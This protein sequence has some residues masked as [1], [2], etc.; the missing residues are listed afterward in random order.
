[1]VDIEGATAVTDVRAPAGGVVTS[2]D[3]VALSLSIVKRS[4]W[5]AGGV[6][7]VLVGMGIVL[8]HKLSWGDVATWTLAVTTLLAFLAAGF[9]GLVA[10]Q[11]LK[12]EAG[13]DLKASE[14]RLQ[15]Q[16]DREQAAEDRTRQLAVA[17]E[18]RLQA[19]AD[20]ELAE[21]DR[22]RQWADVQVQ[23]EKQRRAAERA[24]A[25]KVTAW[26]DDILAFEL[27]TPVSKENSWG[28]R[29]QNASELPIFDVRMFFYWVND[30]QD[31][32]AWTTEERYASVE[33]FRLVPP[34]HSSVLVLPE[35]AKY[36]GLLGKDD[37]LVAIEFTDADGIRWRRDERA[38]LRKL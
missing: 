7:A 14:E 38:A 8:N 23:Q 16:A 10:Y 17:Q 13:R 9:A 21:G 15:A 12:I 1:M 26:M 33:R 25:S 2:P 5:Y 32:S 27:D 30:K 35:K 24:Q 22:I 31:G 20:R 6:V 37:Y 4:R 36:Q 28:A 11:L 29:V 3:P 34:G 18:E 19:Q